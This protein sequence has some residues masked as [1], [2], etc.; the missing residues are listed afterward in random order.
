M[1][2]V[3]HQVR[4]LGRIEAWSASY[5]HRHRGFQLSRIELDM[6]CRPIRGDALGPACAFLPG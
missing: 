6:R 5:R 4:T 3:T 1:G 2:V